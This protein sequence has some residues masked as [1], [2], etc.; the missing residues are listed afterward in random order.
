MINDSWS[1]GE[2][3]GGRPIILIGGSNNVGGTFNWVVWDIF[4]GLIGVKEEGGWVEKKKGEKG[5]GKEKTASKNR[6]VV[7]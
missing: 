6:G 2:I 5:G 7:L 4:P 1:C 3:Q